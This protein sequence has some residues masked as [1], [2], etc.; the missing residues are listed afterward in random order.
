MKQPV[1]NN[2]D[3]E[4]CSLFPRR[5]GHFASSVLRDPC[6]RYGTDYVKPK[7]KPRIFLARKFLE[8][9]ER[10]EGLMKK[11]VPKAFEVYSNLSTGGRNLH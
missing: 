11:H 4:R 9:V 7:S 1:L 5:G 2:C 10:Y 8:F 6:S 3:L